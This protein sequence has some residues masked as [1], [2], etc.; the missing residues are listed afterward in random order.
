MPKRNLPFHDL[1]LGR[2][3]NTT[4]EPE[5]VSTAF[6]RDIENMDWFDEFRSLGKVPGSSVVWNPSGSSNITSLHYFEFVDLDQIRKRRYIASIDFLGGLMYSFEQD[7]G[8]LLTSPSASG[9]EP[10]R[11]A[12]MSQRIHFTSPEFIK[13]QSYATNGVKY[14]GTRLT[15][16][17]V[18]APGLEETT[19]EELDD[20]ANWSTSTDAT[21][22]VDADVSWDGGGS[23]K[24]GKDGTTQAYAR[25]S[26]ASF[27]LDLT[28]TSDDFVYMYLFL[29]SGML[30]NLASTNAI[31]LEFGEG[32]WGVSS[33]WYFQV[34]S[35]LPGWNLL[36]F[37]V[38]NPDATEGGGA[39]MSNL[40][41]WLIGINVTGAAI[42]FDDVRV[43]Y[44]FHYGDGTCTAATGGA[45]QIDATVTYRITFLT[46]YGVESN[47]GP[48]SNSVSPSSEEVDLSNIPTSNDP[49]VIARRIYR[50]LDDDRIYRF[51]D[52]I[53]DNSTTDYTDNTAEAALGGATAPIAGDSL[54]DATPPPKMVAVAT[55]G[56]R[57]WG[58]DARNSNVMWIS[59]VNSPE[60]WKLVDQLALEDEGVALRGHPAG[61]MAYSTDKTYLITGDGVTTPIHSDL[62][63]PQLGANG[64]R[65]VEGA[66]ALHIVA[67]EAEIFGVVN[68]AD[69][70]LMN[71]EVLN[72]F[73]AFTSTDLEDAFI[74]HDRSRFRILFFVSASDTVWV[75]QYGVSGKAQIAADGSV[76]PLDLRVGSWHK[77]VLPAGIDVL[78]AASVERDADLPELWVAGTD[79]S[80]YYISDP[81]ETDYATDGAAEA[82]DAY[83][84][85][86]GVPL[87][88]GPT[89]R[90]EPRYIEF[91]T[92]SVNGA[93]LTVN[94]SLSDGLDSDEIATKA[95][96]VTIPAGNSTI[97]QPIGL[98][99][100]QASWC[101]VK[102][103]NDELGEDYIL[104]RVRLYYIP[105]G[106]FQGEEA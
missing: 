8:T 39:D 27:A 105:R 44:L 50:D 83:V 95:F 15:N 43:D 60:M 18:L 101:R 32:D 80:V 74:I 65:S 28:T 63:G 2:G 106:G 100:R 4:F 75:Y 6:T 67:R 42:T 25:I 104:R 94:L 66:K 49:Q 48:S 37:D 22:E 61:L 76:D 41:R 53:D 72:D 21:L 17:G 88:Q 14:D 38:T 12:V 79:G 19:K 34:G 9:S 98:I 47:L 54:I 82:V 59:D 64:F 73:K 84:E 78:C 62:I 10:L 16:W 52:Q 45:G 11:S 24:I 35:L 29:P 102:L 85:F 7:S 57:I 91:Q 23:L 93:T 56:N 26:N 58:V 90:G 77:L 51:V 89:G 20:D 103:S 99:G 30:Q 70:W 46:E 1:P 68:P 3:M 31:D 81:D 33:H 92:T 40:D 55:H 87:G 71:A 96:T 36:S 69:P 86:H 97:V 5:S 13:V